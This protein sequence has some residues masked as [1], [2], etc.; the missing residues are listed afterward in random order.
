M[1][2]ALDLGRA[3]SDPL[4]F[5]K[6]YPLAATIERTRPVDR[7]RLEFLPAMHDLH[8]ESIGIRESDPRAAARCIDSLDLRR[9]VECCRSAE[10]LGGG[11]FKARSEKAW[12]SLFGY[13]DIG[14]C[15]GTP[16]VEPILAPLRGR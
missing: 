6:A 16:Q 13:V 2:Q 10:I 14:R 3:R 1:T 7:Q 8:L 12:L 15:V 9:P 5:S 11:G 4:Q